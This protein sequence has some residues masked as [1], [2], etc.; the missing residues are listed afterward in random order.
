MEQKLR[1]PG[2]GLGQHPETQFIVKDGTGMCQPKVVQDR[3]DN[4][5]H[6][7]QG[8]VHSGSPTRT[9]NIIAGSSDGIVRLSHGIHNVFQEDD[10]GRQN[11]I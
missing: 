5:V 11:F 8:V 4:C 9:T 2:C 10:Y 7:Y 6:V 3:C 1:E